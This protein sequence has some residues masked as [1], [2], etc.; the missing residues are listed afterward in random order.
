MLVNSLTKFLINLAL[1]NHLVCGIQAEEV[2][3]QTDLTKENTNPISINM[4]PSSGGKIRWE[5]RNLLKVST[6]AYEDQIY[7]NH[8]IYE[9]TG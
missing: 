1:N 9:S 7:T 2:S 3:R 6:E 4:F 8:L 5:E